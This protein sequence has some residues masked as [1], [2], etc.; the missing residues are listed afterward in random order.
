MIFSYTNGLTP[1]ED[2]TMRTSQS[3]EGIIA[4][5]S[6]YICNVVNM[7]FNLVPG[8]D[9]YNSDMG[10]N[11]GAKKFQQYTEGMRDTGYESEIVKQLNTYTDIIPT[12]VIATYTNKHLT[13]FIVAQLNNETYNITVNTDDNFMTNVITERV[14][15]V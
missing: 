13:I 5:R 12:S 15:P 1:H 11:I 3:G 10:L 9:D 8:T 2:I 14:N 4:T 7:L 6:E